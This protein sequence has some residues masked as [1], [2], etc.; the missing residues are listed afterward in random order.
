MLPMQGQEFELRS[1]ML[2][3]AKKKKNTFGYGEFPGGLEIR[4]P[5]F[6]CHGLPSVPGQETK[7]L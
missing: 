6:H 7:V 3:T 4:I 5:G 2:W 1:H